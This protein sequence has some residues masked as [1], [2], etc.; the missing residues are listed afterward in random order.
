MVSYA[1]QSQV[2]YQQVVRPPSNGLAVAA[3][4]LGIVGITVGIWSVVP[5]LGLIAAVFAFVPSVLA[6]IFGIVGWQKAGR[7][8]G[9]GRGQALTGLIL[10]GVTVALIVLVTM[11]WI[12]VGVVGSTTSV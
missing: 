4:V 11:G 7:I 12:F 9:V 10:G 2:I 5:F 3:L 8:G 6:V 1:P